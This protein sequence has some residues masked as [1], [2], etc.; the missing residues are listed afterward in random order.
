MKELYGTPPMLIN[1]CMAVQQNPFH[2][3]MG[4]PDMSFED[5]LLAIGRDRDKQ[6]FMDLF[7]YFAPRIKSFLMKGGATEAQADEL[8]QETMLAIW[9]KAESFN[10]AHAKASTWIYTI[11]RNKRIDALRKVKYIEVDHEDPLYVI[12]DDRMGADDTLAQNEESE[13]LEAAIGKLPE[14]QAFL[15]RKS[16][17]ED[18]SHADIAQET[19]IALGTVKSRIRLALERLRGESKVKTLWH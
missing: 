3:N 13:A 1:A 10:P 18:K 16:F 12:E 5:M 14:D 9:Q 2:G 4:A 6:S 7:R 11:A 8:A 17:Y 15:I 19:G